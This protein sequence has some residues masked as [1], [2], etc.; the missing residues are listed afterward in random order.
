MT[1]LPPEEIELVEIMQTF[2]GIEG[3]RI[4]RGSRFVV[5]DLGP[6]PVMS[7]GRYN[8]LRAMRLAKSVAVYVP[9]R[10]LYRALEA[11]RLEVSFAS[12]GRSSG[13]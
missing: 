3:P 2:L 13:K 11:D 8:Q 10:H 6:A 4:E 5:T 1:Y 7:R 12:R 9:R